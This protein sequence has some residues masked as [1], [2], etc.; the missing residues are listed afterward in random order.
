MGGAESLSSGSTVLPR[1]LVVPDLNLGP[2]TGY[3]EWGFSWFPQSLP[4]SSTLI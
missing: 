1:V 3:P 2:E 4:E